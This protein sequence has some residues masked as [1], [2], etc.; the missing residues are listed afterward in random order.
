[1]KATKITIFIMISLMAMSFTYGVITVQ[2]E[3]FPYELLRKIKQSVGLTIKTELS[4]S[5]YYY[6]KKSFFEQFGKHDYDVVFIGDSLTDGAEWEDLFPSLKIANR[7]ISGDRTD[8][9]LKRLE[10]IYATSAEKA[11]IMV[12]INDFF[13]GV[14]VNDVFANYKTIVD[15]LTSHRMK[16]YIQSTILAGQR[17]PALNSKILELN[18][19]LQ[20]LADESESVT[21]IDL[22]AGLSTDLSL[23]P[24]YSEDG[25][26]LNGKGYSVWKKMIV[27][28]IPK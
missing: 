21:Y 2:Y 19:K 22:N 1:M 9:I 28:Y 24:R 23:N 13:S 12:G 6:R 15:R 3:V 4:H 10:N 7:G 17:Y 11:F 20:R 8:G 18:E 25:I 5:G 16:I 14:P 26:H 27:D